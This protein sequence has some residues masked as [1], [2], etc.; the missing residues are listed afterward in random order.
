M[1][2]LI[3]S[4][5][6]IIADDSLDDEEIEDGKAELI[7][8]SLNA[9]NWPQVFNWLVRFLTSPRRLSDQRVAMAVLLGA[10][11]DGRTIDPNLTTVVLTRL[12]LAE[13]MVDENDQ[14]LAWSIVAKLKGKSYLSS[15]D[16]QQDPDVL[17]ALRN[18]EWT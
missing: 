12:F 18:V 15:Y 10:T 16:P 17:E 8:E 9:E 1:N 14:N 2:D 6:I 11:L 3:D 5:E 4:F 13:S 7:E